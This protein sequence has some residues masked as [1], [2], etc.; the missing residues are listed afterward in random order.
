MR[1]FGAFLAGAV[2]AVLLN[3]GRPVIERVESYCVPIANRVIS[4]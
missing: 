4:M 2:L 3:V 1:Y